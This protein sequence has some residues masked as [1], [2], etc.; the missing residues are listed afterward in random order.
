MSSSSSSRH[1]QISLPLPHTLLPS[2]LTTH[3]GNPPRNPIPISMLH[4]CTSKTAQHNALRDGISPYNPSSAVDVSSSSLPLNIH[5]ETDD[6]D[7]DSE[8]MLP[9]SHITPCS[10]FFILLLLLSLLYSC[11]VLYVVII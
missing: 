4:F 1:D 10:I 5:N 2:S 7:C 11:G 9:L 6:Y 3:Q 8:V